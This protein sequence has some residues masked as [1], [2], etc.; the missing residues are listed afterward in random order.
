MSSSLVSLLGLGACAAM[1]AAAVSCDLTERRIPNRIVLPGALAGLLLA[2]M[3]GGIGVG[4]AL[5]G[6]LAGLAVLM[7]LYLLGA[8]GAGDVKLLASL[9]AYTGGAGLLAVALYGLVAG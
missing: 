3:P 8:T 7:P 4:S 1:L 9:G 2:A 6:M 5:L